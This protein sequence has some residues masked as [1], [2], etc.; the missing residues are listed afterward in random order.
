[1]EQKNNRWYDSTLG[2]I[3][4]GTISAIALS[5]AMLSADYRLSQKLHQKHNTEQRQILNQQN[6]DSKVI[7]PD[8]FYK[9]K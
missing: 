8:K 9:F 5:G 3:V 2:Q 7:D 4:V 1:M 6:L